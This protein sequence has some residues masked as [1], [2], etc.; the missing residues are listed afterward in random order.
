MKYILIFL[1]LINLTIFINSTTLDHTFCHNMTLQYN[2]LINIPEVFLYNNTC[3]NLLLNNTKTNCNEMNK[4][5][6][7]LNTKI[8]SN[9]LESGLILLINYTLL[10]HLCKS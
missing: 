7:L 2:N 5:V 8:R 10:D 9:I 3:Y 6:N 4:L 1:I